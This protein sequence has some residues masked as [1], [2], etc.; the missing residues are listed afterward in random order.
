MNEYELNGEE[1]MDVAEEIVK[2]DSGTGF[3]AGVGIGLALY[4]VGIVAYKYGVKP[5]MA[6]I[7]A[8]KNQQE[9]NRADNVDA[10]YFTEVFEKTTE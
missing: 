6:K 8:K 10:E 2:V 7:K 9:M 1:V 4:G 3:R 5:M